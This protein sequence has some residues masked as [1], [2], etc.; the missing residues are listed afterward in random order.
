MKVLEHGWVYDKKHGII[1]CE[2]GCK[3]EY[4]KEDIKEMAFMSLD[5][6]FQ[7]GYYLVRY[8]ECPECGEKDWIGEKIQIT[9]EEYGESERV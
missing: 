3:Y 4:D 5:G 1:K 8:I 2:C 9:K 7:L 6:A